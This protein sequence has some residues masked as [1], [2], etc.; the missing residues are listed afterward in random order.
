MKRI[1]IVT[2]LMLLIVAGNKVSGQNAG[3]QLANHIAN[4][5]KDTLDLTVAQRNQ[6]FAT[7]MF[8]HNRKMIVRRQTSNPDSLRAGLQREERK[9]DSM[10][11]RI[12]PPAKYQLYLQKKT[13]L[14]SSN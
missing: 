2:S 12:L 8:I 11:H 13:H 9:R 6:V 3:T 4:K 1:V 10:Y 14:V 5:M 7:N